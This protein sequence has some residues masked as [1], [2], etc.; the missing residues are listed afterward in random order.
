VQGGPSVVQDRATFQGPVH[1]GGGTG[2]AGRGDGDAD[3]RR[4]GDRAAPPGTRLEGHGDDLTD[5]R[6]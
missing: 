3:G 4:S 6:R 1:F 5:G 2:A